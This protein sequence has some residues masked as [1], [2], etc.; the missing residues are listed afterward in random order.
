MDQNTPYNPRRQF[1]LAPEEFF[2][3][4]DFLN[5]Y[6]YL[7]ILKELG[8]LRPKTVLEI[9][10]GEGT[11]KRIYEPFIE[12][13]ATIDVNERLHP[14][15]RSDVR[16]RVAAAER[17]FDAVV[18]ADIL[19]HIPFDDM[20]KALANIH[21]YLKHGGH[22]LITIPHRASNFLWMTPTQIPHSF[23]VPTGFLS[24]GAFWR[25]FIKRKIWIDP[26]HRWEIGD[27]H[28]TAKEVQ[29]LMRDAGF[30]VDGRRSILYVD[31]WT[32]KRQ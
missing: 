20:P 31:F 2:A 26:D 11:V 27:G 23:R 15:F 19:E 24:P 9:G 5:W 25:R 6:R 10:P 18:A 13:Y 21:A 8:R 14:T 7:F 4:L 32:L 16:D 17:R 12:E 28:H 1:E 29:R 30:A 22:A 3:K